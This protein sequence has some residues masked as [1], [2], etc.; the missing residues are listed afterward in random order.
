MINRTELRKVPSEEALAACRDRTADV[1]KHIWQQQCHNRTAQPD[2]RCKSTLYTMSTSMNSEM[3][4][5]GQSVNLGA[6]CIELVQPYGL[7]F[8][9]PGKWTMREKLIFC[10]D[11]NVIC[12]VQSRLKKYTSSRET[13]ITPTTR[14]IPSR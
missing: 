13:Q 4:A 12:P 7:L 1:R 9:P 8:C 2:N 11:F 6:K 10:N 14:A 5:V 3:S